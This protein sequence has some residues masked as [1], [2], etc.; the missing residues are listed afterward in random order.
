[1]VEGRRPS[2]DREQIKIEAAQGLAKTFFEH[3][4]TSS[5]FGDYVE[6]LTSFRSVGEILDF[7]TNLGLIPQDLERIGYVVALAGPINR[8]G[9]KMP[10]AISQQIGEAL[11]ESGLP[12]PDWYVQENDLTPSR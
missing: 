12:I 4:I 10:S 7:T 3:P 2:L 11:I 9:R 5:I 8:K 6:K 1:M